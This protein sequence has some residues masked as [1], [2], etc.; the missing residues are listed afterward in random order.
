MSGKAVRETVG[1]LA[2]VASMVF[3]GLEIRAS[4]TQARA[5]AYQAI[6]VATAENWITIAEDR[7]RN[8]LFLV[9]QSDAALV[10]EWDAGDWAQMQAAWT[11]WMRLAETVLLQVEQG[12]LPAGAMERLGYANVVNY[13]KIPAFVCL[14]PRMREQIGTEV[15]R[16][17]VERSTPVS[18]DCRGLGMP[19]ALE[20]Q[21]L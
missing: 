19:V 12:L 14:W 6:G 5:A 4:N 11:S 10:A 13:L 20:A 15:F 8:T 7:R 18:V 17:Y 3:V 9:E 1:F 16:Q 21:G 2:V